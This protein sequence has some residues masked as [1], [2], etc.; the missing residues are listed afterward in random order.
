M[1]ATPEDDQTLAPNNNIK[2][3]T[4]D[5]SVLS[6]PSNSELSIS[7]EL[8]EGLAKIAADF[9]AET[10]APMHKASTDTE[11]DVTLGPS[12]QHKHIDS[13]MN[14]QMPQS[15]HA[16]PKNDPNAA[17]MPPS[18]YAAPKNDPNA[19]TM[20]PSGNAAPKNDPNA[21]TLSPADQA[22]FDSFFDSNSATMPP[23]GKAPAYDPNSA[24]MP[25]SQSGAYDP[26]GATM[27][28]SQ[29]GAY[30]PNGATMPPSQSGAYDPNGATMPPSQSGAYDP[31]GATMAPG[32]E[33]KSGNTAV[34]VGSIKPN[35]GGSKFPNVPGYDI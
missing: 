23:D 21:A 24:T 5:A 10:I 14:L 15:G 33:S 19:A 26:N 28:P 12:H 9:G 17:T 20:P 35:S 1:A 8:K 13:T 25:P 11:H 16:T 32:Q 29:S 2:A 31:N 22:L 3:A 7:P 18:G 34:N 6:V 30:D 4:D 27:P